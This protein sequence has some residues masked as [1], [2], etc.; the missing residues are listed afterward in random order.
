[1]AIKIKYLIVD[2]IRV[3][4]LSEYDKK[5]NITD[6][7]SAIIKLPNGTTL[8]VPKEGGKFDISGCGLHEGR[9]LYSKLYIY[10]RQP[11]H[12]KYGNGCYFSVESQNIKAKEGI[13]RVY[14]QQKSPLICF[15]MLNS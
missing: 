6:A 4:E 2:P 11:N 13:A 15:S 10:D 3:D 9:N 7:A 5:H 8:N 1:M 14:Y 12:P